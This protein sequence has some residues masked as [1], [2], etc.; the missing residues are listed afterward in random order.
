[1]VAENKSI[2]GIATTFNKSKTAVRHWLSKYNLTTTGKAGGKPKLSTTNEGRCCTKCN[3][4]KL[5]SEYTPRKDR[6]NTVLPVCKLCNSNSVIDKE[7]KLKSMCIQYSGG[8]CVKCGLTGEQYR[9]VFDFHHIEPEHKDFELR[10]RKSASFNTIAS[11]LS[12]CILLC[13][14]CHQHTHHEMKLVSGY[15]NKIKDNTELWQKNKQRK[16]DY[17]QKNS[18]DICNYNTYSGA[19]GIVFQEQDK[20]FRKYNKTHWDNDFTA[21]LKRSTIMCLNCV[22]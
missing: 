19:L 10:S 18:C 20:H 17:L 8:K 4:F 12:K 7:H 13:A 5:Y 9:K 6:L 1:M 16:L 21:A 15:T 11:E 22:R 3:V 14:N 2:Q